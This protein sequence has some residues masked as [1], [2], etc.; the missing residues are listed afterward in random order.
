MDSK[1]NSENQIKVYLEDSQ[2]WEGFAALKNE[3]ILTKKGRSMFPVMKVNISNLE[4]NS[5]YKIRMEFR[6]VGE[7]RYKYINRKWYP[8]EKVNLL[9]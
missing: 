3:M 6:Q 1:T 9:T 7:N 8:G 4:V 5:L 2:L